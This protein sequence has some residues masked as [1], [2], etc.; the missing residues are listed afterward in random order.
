VGVD[1][2]TDYTPGGQG[3]I[4]AKW[5]SIKQ[6]FIINEMMAPVESTMRRLKNAAIAPAY[7]RNFQ[8]KGAYYA[9]VKTPAGENQFLMVSKTGKVQGPYLVLQEMMPNT[10]HVSG[11]C[12]QRPCIY[13]HPSQ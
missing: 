11:E 13:V 8:Y 10:R 5:D 1:G 3:T 6:S 9:L 7:F 4:A 2:N 12:L